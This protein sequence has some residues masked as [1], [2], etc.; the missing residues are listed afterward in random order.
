M[1]PKGQIKITNFSEKVLHLFKLM[2]K[3]K[4]FRFE[5][6]LAVEILFM[7]APWV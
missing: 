1:M 4:S 7:S 6:V 2:Q 5:M 3:I